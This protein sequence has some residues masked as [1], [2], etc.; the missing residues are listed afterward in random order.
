MPD[1]D[2]LT[3]L[4]LTSDGLA[5]FVGA[6]TTYFDYYS[7]LTDDVGRLPI[8]FRSNW[9]VL[10]VSVGCGAIAAVACWLSGTN[11]DG[12]LSTILT[13]KTSD[14]WRGLVVGASVLILLRSKL[15]NIQDSP[16]G[17]DFLYRFFQTNAVQDVNRKWFAMKKRFKEQTIDAALEI[18]TFK[19]DIDAAVAIWIENRPQKLKDSIDDKLKHLRSKRPT[20][21]F[22]AADPAWKVHYLGLIDVA[23]DAGGP[24]E[25]RRSFA[26]FV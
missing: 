5:L 15:F 19:A 3:G 7:K 10:L 22:A 2:P 6:L 25:L 9:I 23:L 18:S 20:A 8:A 13:V 21:V 17:G 12:V 4:A 16:F 14:P 26:G 11:P 24:V 1:P